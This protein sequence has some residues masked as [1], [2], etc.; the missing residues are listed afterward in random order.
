MIRSMTGFGEAIRELPRG[1]LR[2]TVKTVNHRFF[3]PHLRTPQGFDRFE[4]E[5]Q[6]WLKGFFSRGHVN[7]T[8]ILEKGGSTP[9]EELPELDMER[10]RH[11]RGL[12]DRLREEVGVAGEVDF[13]SLLRFGDLFRAPETPEVEDQAHAELLRE[14]VEDAAHAARIMRE[15]EGARLRKD[16]Q[17]RLR[18]MEGE[19]KVIEERAPLRLVA[20]RDRLRAAVRELTLQEEVDEDRLAKEIAYLA[21]RWDINEEIVRFRAH[22]EA[23]RETLEE[24]E[25]KP[26]GKR[27]GFLVQEMHRE[28]NTIASKG[29]DVE[30]GHA[31]V[32]VREE[33]ER[34]RE[35]L[36]NVE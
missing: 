24:E 4:G 16:L 32:A 34:L 15:E 21:E 19:L 31:S 25:D 3:N 26:V 28:A 13:S 5:I 29:N 9:L 10:A 12:L 7:L 30:I 17:G 23:F 27:L 11:Y 35:Q 6:T 1:Q 33:I 8:I 20:E 22:L 36:E 18:A 14:L 2:A